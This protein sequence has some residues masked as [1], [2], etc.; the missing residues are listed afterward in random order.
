MWRAFVCAAEDPNRK[1]DRNNLRDS[2][3][4]FFPQA[5]SADVSSSSVCALLDTDNLRETRLEFAEGKVLSCTD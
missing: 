3:N 1:T 4:R 2:R 5:I